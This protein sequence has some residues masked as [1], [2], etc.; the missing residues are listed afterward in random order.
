MSV[1][2][3]GLIWMPALK[4]HALQCGR[5][6]SM[7]FNSSVSHWVI[8]ETTIGG[9][10]Q[11]RLHCLRM[12]RLTHFLQSTIQILSKIE[13]TSTRRSSWKVVI[14]AGSTLLTPLFL[15]TNYFPKSKCNSRSP[16]ALLVLVFQNSSTCKSQR[17]CMRLTNQLFVRVH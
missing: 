14:I 13:L 4:T 3:W 9:T 10:R 12:R 11:I 6:A 17:N 1:E 7:E 8:K 5:M 16:W 15:M 2:F